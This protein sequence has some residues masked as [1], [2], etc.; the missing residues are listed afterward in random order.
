MDRLIL[1]ITDISQ[2]GIVFY[3]WDS[4]DTGV[5]TLQLRL[6]NISARGLL[7]VPS[8]IGYER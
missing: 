7:Y 8:H 6:A 5:H 1:G 3:L 2:A 4:M